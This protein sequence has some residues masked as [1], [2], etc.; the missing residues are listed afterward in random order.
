MELSWLNTSAEFFQKHNFLE[1]LNTKLL[2]RDISRDFFYL[3]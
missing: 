2:A 3:C 1:C